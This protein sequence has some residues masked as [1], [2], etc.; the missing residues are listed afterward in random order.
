M[1][2]DADLILTLNDAGPGIAIDRV[3]AEEL[4][5][6]FEQFR[7][8]AEAARKR[9]Q[10]NVDPHDYRQALIDISGSAR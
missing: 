10:F 4:A 6:E 8:A 5:A 3:R 9:T 1:S 7:A 2:I